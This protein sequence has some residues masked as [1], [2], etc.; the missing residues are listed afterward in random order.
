[1][2]QGITAQK[3]HLFLIQKMVQLE[4]YALK[5]IIVKEEIL[6]Q[7][8]VIQE[9]SKVE[10]DRMNVKIVL[11]DSI[12]KEAPPYLK[13]VLMDSAQQNLINQLHVLTE[14]MP[15]KHQSNSY[16]QMIAITVQMEYSVI[17]VTS[18]EYLA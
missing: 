17:V 18:V 3:E 6:H 13:S 5:V 1:M 11:K 8:P 14:H 16:H 2:I 4:T 12:V 15:M 7:K 9:H 10:K